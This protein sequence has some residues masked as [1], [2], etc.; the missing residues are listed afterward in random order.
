MYIT[1]GGGGG[2]DVVGGD[3][4]GGGGMG[5]SFFKNNKSKT[6]LEILVICLNYSDDENS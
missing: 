6:C 1:S 2:G 3:G 5:W 4:G